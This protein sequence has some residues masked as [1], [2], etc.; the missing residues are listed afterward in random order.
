MTQFARHGLR[1]F[2]RIAKDV[3]RFSSKV[4]LLDHIDRM[5]LSG[6]SQ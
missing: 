4:E 3:A 5:K 2:S 6:A 1:L